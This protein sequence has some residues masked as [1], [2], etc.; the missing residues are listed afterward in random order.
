ME[1]ALSAGGELGGQVTVDNVHADFPGP[2]GG[3]SEFIAEVPSQKH[4][5]VLN[6]LVEGFKRL[7]VAI[8]DGPAKVFVFQK[9]DRLSEIW[10][11][12]RLSSGSQTFAR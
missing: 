7:F 2:L 5:V 9:R 4:D 3:V 1:A 11:W 8:A 12:G 6:P 10:L